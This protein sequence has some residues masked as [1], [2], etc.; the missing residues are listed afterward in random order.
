V[1]LVQAIFC[2]ILKSASDLLQAQKA[3][4]VVST[5]IA[6]VG[7]A[8]APGSQRIGQLIAARTLIGLALAVIPLTFAVPSEALPTIWR[9]SMY[10]M[11]DV[12]TRCISRLTVLS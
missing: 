4:L 11:S 12:E 8:I 5:T 1:V 7:A 6:F 3:L 2:N 10:P 9:P